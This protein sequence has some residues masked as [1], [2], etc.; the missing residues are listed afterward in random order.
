MEICKV[1]GVI[2]F[3][4]DVHKRWHVETA[5]I[6]TGTAEALE[7]IFVLL[8]SLSA[9]LEATVALSGLDMAEFEELVGQIRGT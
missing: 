5:T 3:D 8:G 7:T 2:P 6:E 9:Q 4:M 1:C